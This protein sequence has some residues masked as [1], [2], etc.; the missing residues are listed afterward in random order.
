MANL[1]DFGHPFV[2]DRNFIP[3]KGT[4]FYSWLDVSST[5]STSQISKAYR[6]KSMLLQYV[7]I[8][9]LMHHQSLNYP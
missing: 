3:G 2:D 6:K 8:F 1:N 7:D 4:S 9:E 5:A